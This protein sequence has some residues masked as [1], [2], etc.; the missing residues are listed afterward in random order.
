MPDIL[1]LQDIFNK[2]L[3]EEFCLSLTMSYNI[4]KKLIEE[5]KDFVENQKEIACENCELVEA[6][7]NYRRAEMEDRD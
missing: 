2:I 3:T 4:I 6:P 1:D 7:V 5:V